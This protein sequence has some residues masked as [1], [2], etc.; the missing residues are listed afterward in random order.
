MPYCD[1]IDEEAQAIGSVNTLVRG[2]DGRL[3]AYNTDAVGFRFMARRAGID[4]SGAKTVILGSGGASLTAAAMA[5]RLGAREVVTVSRTG[6]N[7]YDNL[8][9]HADADIVVN[10]TPVGM[11]PNTGCSAVE[12]DSFPRCR[13]VLDVIYNPRR[14]AL[15]HAGGGAGAFP[16]P[17]GCP[18]WWRRPR[19]RR[20]GSS[21]VSV[22]DGETER[23]LA[24]LRRE[25][26]NIVLIGM[27]GSGKSTVGARAG[28]PSRA[29]RP[30][31]WTR[32]SCVRPD[33]PFP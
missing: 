33:A 16:A 15:L 10:A 7:N 25:T 1:V 24:L 28:A 30:W 8:S 18:C 11:Y 23:I 5:A 4:F 22:A 17:T 14:T 31:I 6:E 3:Y 12:L 21:A 27:P 2:E 29:V 9:L 19:R 13:G 20:N 32:R 26:Q